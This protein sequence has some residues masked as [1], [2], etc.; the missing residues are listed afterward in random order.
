M[1]RKIRWTEHAAHMGETLDSYKIL[2][3][4]PDGIIIPIIATSCESV[5][6]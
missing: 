5:G 3:R 2:V 4:K 6:D 1:K